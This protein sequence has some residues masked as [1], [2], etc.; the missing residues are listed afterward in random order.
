MPGATRPRSRRPNSSAVWR[1]WRWTTCSS[2][3]FGTALPV[4]GPVGE[5]E[6]GRAAVADRAAVGAGVGQ[7]HPGARVARGLVG[8]RQVA[9][10]VVEERRVDHAVAVVAGELVDAA[11]PWRARRR[12]AAMAATDVSLGGLVVDVGAVDGPHAVRPCRARRAG[13]SRRRPGSR[14]RAG[15]GGRARRGRPGGPASA[16]R[17]PRRRRGGTG[18]GARSRAGSRGCR[19]TGRRPGRRCRGPARRPSSSWRSTCRHTSGS[20]SGWLRF[21]LTVRPDRR[22]RSTIHGHSWIGHPGVVGRELEHAVTGA[23]R[24][25]RRWP[26]ARR[27][28]RRCP[29]PARRPSS[30]AAACGSCENPSA[31]ARSASS[32][33]S[34]MRS[35]VVGGGGL[36][37]GAP[38]AH[39]EGAERS[40]GDLGAD[41][42]HLGLPLDGIEVLGEAGPLPA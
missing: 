5:H 28:P 17:R 34:A 20:W 11:P 26:A 10:A 41:V 3:S 21:T 29:A 42:D 1:V 19:S 12:A 18:A 24:A 36:V 16:G 14:A 7:A 31:P 2:G 8:H 6:R 37:G 38:L 30:G 9:V 33:S 32:T 15:G 40:V 13:R 22:A 23:A 25:H 27:A 35:G 39:H 4:A